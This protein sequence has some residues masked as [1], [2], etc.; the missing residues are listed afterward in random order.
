MFLQA[1]KSTGR[2]RG[3]SSTLLRKPAIET[4]ASVILVSH[5]SLAGIASGTGLSGSTAWH[6]TV[7]ERVPIS[8]H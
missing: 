7:G 8:N 4:G 5:P 3:I 1:T 2:R 6:N